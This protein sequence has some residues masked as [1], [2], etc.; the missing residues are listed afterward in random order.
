[1]TLKVDDPSIVGIDES[2]GGDAIVFS[3]TPRAVDEVIVNGR[4]I[5]NDGVHEQYKTTCHH[6]LGV[7]RKLGLMP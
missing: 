6:Y 5:V 3:A 2:S 4:S 7:L 1:M